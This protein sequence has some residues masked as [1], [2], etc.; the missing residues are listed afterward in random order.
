MAPSDGSSPASRGS[1]HSPMTRPVSWGRSSARR[2]RTRG[3]AL[4][5]REAMSTV[6]RAVRMITA[7]PGTWCT[8]GPTVS[9]SMPEMARL[10]GLGPPS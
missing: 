3:S 4:T 9:R 10:R 1:T 6:V 2:T 8:I 7:W 5:S